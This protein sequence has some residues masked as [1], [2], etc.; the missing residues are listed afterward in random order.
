MFLSCCASADKEEM[1]C[2]ELQLN[3]ISRVEP[4]DS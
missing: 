2:N 4:M 1:N 3:V